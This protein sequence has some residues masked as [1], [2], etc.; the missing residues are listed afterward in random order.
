VIFTHVKD[1]LL[2]ALLSPFF[3]NEFQNFFPNFRN[4]SCLLRKE[5]LHV[6]SQRLTTLM[7]VP[8]PHHLLEQF[9]AQIA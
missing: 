1:I 3:F 4:I 6:A 7:P 8:T 9:P 2:F 5:W